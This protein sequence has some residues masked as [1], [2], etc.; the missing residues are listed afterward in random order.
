MPLLVDGQRKENQTMPTLEKSITLVVER[1]V[2][3]AIARA[4]KSIR[5]PT[6]APARRGRP[7]S[8]VISAAAGEAAAGERQWF[9]AKGIR[10]M[11][12]KL[13]LS[14]VELGKLAD[15]TPQA[16][17]LWESKN[18]R[19]RLRRATEAKLQAV[20]AMGI[21]E[22]RKALADMGHVKAK[23]GRKP[24]AVAAAP[25]APKAAP[26]PKAPKT[27]RRARRASKK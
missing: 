18:G 22:A 9:L 27:K 8:T 2:K 25:K 26:A 24:K 23:P 6:A 7:P 11:R 3:R 14:Q 21:R 15:V 13:K 20:R 19:L 5:I 4:M 1:A 16:V 12:K 10:S 17:M